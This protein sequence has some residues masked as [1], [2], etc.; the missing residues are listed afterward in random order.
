MS[1][2]AAR[3]RRRIIG[4][5]DSTPARRS[6][7]AVEARLG[8]R[9]D[10]LGPWI[11]CAGWRASSSRRRGPSRCSSLCPR[12]SSSRPAR[13]PSGQ[14]ASRHSA[15]VSPHPAPGC[16]DPLHSPPGVR[17]VHV[18]GLGALGSP[19]GDR[20]ALD[21]PLVRGRH[22]AP[23]RPLRGGAGPSGGR[24]VGVVRQLSAPAL[25]GDA[26]SVRALPDHQAAGHGWPLVGDSLGPRWSDR[27]DGRVVRHLHRSVDAAPERVVRHRPRLGRDDCALERPTQSRRLHRLVWWGCSCSLVSRG[28]RACGTSWPLPGRPRI[29]RRRVSWPGRTSPTS[30]TT[31]GSGRRWPCG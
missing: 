16:L 15:V 10:T 1:N 14:P 9:W 11:A 19:V 12:R 21:L 24:T 3:A 23:D 13:G 30:G 18:P 20:G 8:G 27:P 4:A 26:A 31:H 5:V 25:P 7:G 22:G 28:R 2:R 29:G 6:T 17:R